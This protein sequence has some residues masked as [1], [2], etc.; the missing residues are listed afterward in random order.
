[1]KIK[2]EM[3]REQAIELFRACEIIA[4]CGMYQFSDLI[5]ALNPDMCFD[6][7]M[8]IE[9]DL[10]S[11]LPKIE[12][13]RKCSFRVAWDAY[14]VLRR[15]VAWFDVGLDWRKDKRD[16]SKMMS[17]WFDEPMK[18]NSLDGFFKTELD[19]EKECA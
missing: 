2:L 11:K 14:Q 13:T 18:T 8:K 7:R 16:W 12:D 6:D 10:K 1:M 17:V 19:K 4:R 15:E 9:N 3:T 5:S